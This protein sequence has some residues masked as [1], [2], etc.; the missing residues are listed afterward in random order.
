[1]PETSE[2]SAVV[3]ALREDLPHAL[4]AVDFD[5]TLAPIVADPAASRPLP[6][7]V[8]ALTAIAKRGARVAIISGRDVQTVMELGGL[9]AVPGL[10]VAGLHGAE[11]WR[12]GAIYTPDTPEVIRRLRDRLPG[13]VDR[14]AID[15]RVW[16]EDKRLS[17]VVHGRL[18]DDPESALDPL[19]GPIAE[20]G[21]ELG[22]D[23][24]PG[25][26]VIELRLPDIDKGGALRRIVERVSARC[27][28]YI[29]DDVGDLPAF[30]AVAELRDGGLPAWSV[31]VATREV[32][33]VAAAANLTVDGPAGVLAL[34]AAIAG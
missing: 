33:E 7:A 20:L 4:V 30:A 32:P 29:G 24:H 28:L 16:I 5:G 25:R 18:T 21:D 1:M 6:G 11:E 9:A 23:V 27:V 3:L 34:L 14:Q 8:D 15:P 19:R 22:L 31:A 12:D 10:L 17:L 2:V 26:G 13:L